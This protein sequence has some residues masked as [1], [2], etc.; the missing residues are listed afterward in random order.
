MKLSAIKRNRAVIFVFLLLNILAWEDCLSKSKTVLDMLGKNVSLVTKYSYRTIDI[1]SDQKT[2]SLPKYT[3]AQY[4]I[5]ATESDMIL[6]F[7]KLVKVEHYFPT[8]IP[9]FLFDEVTFSEDED[10]T[11]VFPNGFVKLI[12]KGN[13]VNLIIIYPHSTDIESILSKLIVDERDI[14]DI[15]SFP[16]AEKMNIQSDMIVLPLMDY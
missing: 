16:V 14:Q 6:Y 11:P 2:D 7:Y 10:Y 15:C 5:K 3:V 9:H 1:D 12:N 8:I 13:T 4:S